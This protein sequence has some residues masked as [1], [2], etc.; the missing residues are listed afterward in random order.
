M[1]EDNASLW[2]I[3]AQSWH[4]QSVP[5][6]PGPDD[7]GNYKAAL[8]TIT[9][10]AVLKHAII[11]GVTPELHELLKN[12]E[13]C[14][15]SI[16]SNRQMI[17]RVWPGSIDTA[18]C[19]DWIKIDEL[20]IVFDLCVCDGGFHLLDFRNQASLAEKLGSMTSKGSAVVF[21]L[22]LPPESHQTISTT[23]LDSLENGQ[24]QDLNYLKVNLWH[25]ADLN[26]GGKVVLTDIWKALLKRSGNDVPAYLSSLGFS[27]PE[28]EAVCIYENN[29]AAYYF[30][31]LQSVE[32]MFS[33]RAGLELT[34]VKYPNYVQGE[35][36][37]VITFKKKYDR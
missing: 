3:Y 8:H 23:I 19:N 18:I 27:L 9:D 13:F 33:V 28:I 25:A 30:S 2:G 37:P 31:S 10:T 12:S 22:F 1:T 17:E 21:R 11:L 24:I 32:E 14:V 16:D 15:K 35:Q 29:N 7:I 5:L 34:S 4:G 20:G 26:S 36:F 6:R